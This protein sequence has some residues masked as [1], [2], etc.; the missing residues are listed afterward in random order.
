MG[1]GAGH[2][3][4]EFDPQKDSDFVGLGNSLPT[5]L[6]GVEVKVNRI[7]AAVYYINS[8]QIRPKGRPA[9]VLRLR[10]S[11]LE[12][13]LV[14][15]APPDASVFRAAGASSLAGRFRAV[16]RLLGLQIPRHAAEPQLP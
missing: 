3:S 5:K 6:D 13:T 14:N 15:G 1:A 11:P 7:S 12:C 9:A 10:A 16:F 4:L 8:T 2:E